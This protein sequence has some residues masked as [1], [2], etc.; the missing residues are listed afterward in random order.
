MDYEK[1]QAI[2]KFPD[3]RASRRGTGGFTLIEL[4]V[5]IAIIA[6]LASMLLPSLSRAKAKAQSV[7]CMSNLKQWGISW[8]MYADENNGKFSEGTGVNWARGEWIY[9]L[10]KHYEKKPHLLYCPTAS[11]RRGPGTQETR[12]PLDSAQAVEY[13]GPT[14]AYDFPLVDTTTAPNARQRNITSS[15]GINNW[16]YSPA[17]GVTAIQGRPTSRNWRRFD[18]PP[19]PT[20]TPLFG[21]TMWRGGGPH[22]NDAVPAFNGEWKG[23]GAEFCHFAIRRHGKGSNLLFFD[24]S[25]RMVR[26]RALWNLPWNKE[27]DLTYSS[28]VVFP[29]WMQ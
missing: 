12:L 19:R 25:V 2:M 14:T 16:V 24:N 17:A 10:R 23:A 18:A 9:A 29:A 22:H 3:D 7:N 28:R 5:V 4:L 13:G 20:E 27:F 8:M 6:I 26:T 21:D 1:A 15:Y 11:M